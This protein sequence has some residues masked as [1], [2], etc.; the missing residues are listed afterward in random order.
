MKT[1]L[2]LTALVAALL[3][4]LACQAA[5]EQERPTDRPPNILFIAVDDLRPELNCYGQS[6]ILSPHLDQ[7][8]AE[9]FLFERAY[10]NVPVCGASRASI[11]T[12]LRPNPTRF[13]SY[14]TVANEDAPTAISLPQ[15]FK[16]NGYHTLSLGKVFHHRSDKPKSWSETPWLPQL[17]A[18][19][20]TGWRD[21]QIPEHIAMDADDDP[22]RGP[23]MENAPVPDSTYFDGKIAQKAIR[24]L[25]ELGKKDQ[26]F[27]MAVGFLKPHLPFNAPTK[28]WD[29]YPPDSIELP[30]YMQYP[31]ES[32]NQSHHSFG[33][34][35]HYHGIP[36]EGRVSDSLAVN[37]IRAYYACVSYVDAMIG[38]VLNALEEQGLNDNTIV[39]LWGDHGWSLGEHGLWCKH[40]TFNVAMQAPLMIRVPGRKGGQRIQA[41]TE[42]V[43]VYPS[44][45]EL[46]GLAIPDHLQG[47]SFVPLLDNP[48]ANGKDA[49]FCR[50]KKSDVIKTD[51]WLYTEW[52]D[53]EDKSVARMLYDHENDPNETVNV[54]ERPEN[55]EVVEAF[56]K[57][58]LEQRKIK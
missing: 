26:P 18:P 47:D 19:A 58:L 25:K 16:Q 22:I 13:L 34:L 2:L 35:R 50:W 41:L 46:A 56:N 14:N 23:A 57:R 17:D 31:A 36:R 55:R 37:L 15:H 33:E 24:K 48:R 8:A 51:R 54:A 11:L 9:G 7:L 3:H 38:N 43:D 6:Q 45:V 52:F 42:F 28:Y 49:L 21:Y 39:I 29:L 40:S 30:R 44:L 32:P 10:C 5:T 4:L 12:G 53:Q 1:N 27:F 20:G